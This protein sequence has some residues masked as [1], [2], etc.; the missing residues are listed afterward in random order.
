MSPWLLGGGLLANN[1]LTW[2]S[3]YNLFP[4]A[5][6]VE[7]RNRS[8]ALNAQKA[9]WRLLIANN[10]ITVAEVK[11]ELQQK[12]KQCYSH[13]KLFRSEKAP[14]R[15]CWPQFP[16]MEHV[17]SCVIHFPLRAINSSHIASDSYICNQA[18]QFS[19]INQLR[20]YALSA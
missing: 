10:G 20:A 11:V 18:D 13:S 2:I 12:P 15:K 1:L 4:S 6:F 7:G 8:A 19:S 3:L 14:W 16:G 9:Q 5:S 17:T